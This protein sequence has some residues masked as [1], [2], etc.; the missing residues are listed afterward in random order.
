MYV[1][2]HD[3]QKEAS[4][5]TNFQ[6]RSLFGQNQ[7]IHAFEIGKGHNT[8]ATS[9]ATSTTCL[10]QV[11]W[12]SYSEPAAGNWGFKFKACLLGG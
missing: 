6:H 5:A 11:A 7:T 3:I 2:F 1:L 9:H 8:S 10:W 12:I 4:E